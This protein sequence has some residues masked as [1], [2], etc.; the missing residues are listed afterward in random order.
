MIIQDGELPDSRNASTT[1][2]LLIM[3]SFF[4]PVASFIS[5]ESS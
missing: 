5:E 4:W 3:R 2:S 1:S